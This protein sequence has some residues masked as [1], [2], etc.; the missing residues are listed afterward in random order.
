MNLPYGRAEARDWA[1]ALEMARAHCPDVVLVNEWMWNRA[2]AA[3]MPAL[4]RA[5]PEACVLLLSHDESGDGASPASG[6]HGCLPTDAGLAELCDA[7]ATMLGGRCSS[8]AFR[9]RCPIPRIAVALSRREQQ[10]AI[11]VAD[12]LTSK[13]IAADLGLSLRTVHTYRESL[14]R[15]LGASSAA[16]VT[17]FVLE[18]GLT[19]LTSIR[20]AR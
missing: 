11:R 5:V 19:D 8:C 13:R 15:K 10:V 3:T 4:R 18:S 12:G 1:T 9:P 6:A 20:A 16:V 14:A 7:V 17:R 2:D